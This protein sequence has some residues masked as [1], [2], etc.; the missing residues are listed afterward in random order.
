MTDEF[1]HS[2]DTWA[3]ARR[4]QLHAGSSLQRWAN[5]VLHS[6]YPE[7]WPP[8]RLCRRAR[9]T[10]HD[11]IGQ[12][13]G[14]LWPGPWCWASLGG[15]GGAGLAPHLQFWTVGT[16]SAWHPASWGPP[17]QQMLACPWRSLG[18]GQSLHLLVS[19]GWHFS[20]IGRP[21]KELANLQVRRNEAWYTEFCHPPLSRGLPCHFP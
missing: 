4:D 2:P 5:T 7:E 3:P 19:P 9:C 18:S 14:Q 6:L 11:L 8:P 16:A 17:T 12:L 15:G 21:D 10:T 20:P 1:S 13:S